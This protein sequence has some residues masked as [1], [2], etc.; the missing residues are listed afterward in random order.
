[1][2]EA[3][4]EKIRWVLFESGLGPNDIAKEV[5]T[6]RQAISNFQ[7]GRRKIEKMNFQ[8]ASSISDFYDRKA[9]K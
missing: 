5:G 2:L 8:L 6:S 1:M 7:S 9:E 4:E 3:S